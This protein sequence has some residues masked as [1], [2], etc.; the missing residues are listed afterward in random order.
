MDS[1]VEEAQEVSEIL[2]FVENDVDKEDWHDKKGN[3]KSKNK[4]SKSKNPIVEV[5]QNGVEET[6]TSTEA[7]EKPEKPQKKQKNQKHA[8]NDVKEKEVD[9]DHVCVGM[10]DIYSIFDI[11]HK[12]I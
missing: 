6:S 9:T 5:P 10:G 1:D 4:K 3:K 11:I 12:H 8:E 2:N 7:L